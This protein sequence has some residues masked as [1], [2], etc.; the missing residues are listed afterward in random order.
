MTLSSY[1][2]NLYFVLTFDD[3]QTNAVP[4]TKDL[5]KRIRIKYL[6]K[7]NTLH[8][9]QKQRNYAYLCSGNWKTNAH[10]RA[11]VDF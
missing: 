10:C 5:C 4:K 9:Y 3:T 7:H 6:Q 11:F 1:T 2:L 8:L